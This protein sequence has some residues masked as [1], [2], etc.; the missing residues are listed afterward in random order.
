MDLTRWTRIQA[1]AF[2][3]WR[4]GQGSKPRDEGYPE[5]ERKEKAPGITKWSRPHSQ[6][7]SRPQTLVLASLIVVTSIVI[8]SF[9]HGLG[10][11]PL[12]A[13]RPNIKLRDVE[14]C[15]FRYLLLI[16]LG[17]SIACASFLCMLFGCCYT[18]HV[19][20]SLRDLPMMSLLL[21]H[22]MQFPTATGAC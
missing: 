5:R 17:C 3:C 16:R 9:V 12:C 4:R 11:L 18:N 19:F 1:Y 22:C 21:S 15:N 6:V 13:A 8:A 2:Q 10:P 7:A 14:A 20:E